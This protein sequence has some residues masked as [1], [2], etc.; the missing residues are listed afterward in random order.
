MPG[1]RIIALMLLIASMLGSCVADPQQVTWPQPPADRPVV[2][3]AF[4]MADDL[5]SATGTER[6]TF[7]PDAQICELVFR[8]WPNKPATART[9]NR[10][11]VESV[12]V[13]GIRL[14]LEVQAAGA[15]A[16]VPGTLVEATLP[17]CVPP[18][19][20]ITADLTF[21]LRLGDRTDERVG[22]SPQRRVAW[23]GS[24]YPMLAW[25]RGVGWTRDSAVDVV[26]ESATSEAFQLRSLT[27]EAPD[28][29][30]VAGMGEPGATRP[31]SRAGTNAHTFSSEVVRDVSVVVGRIDLHTS[32]VG[33]TRLTVALP[34]DAR[35]SAQVWRD[36]VARQLDELSRLLGPVPAKH[37]W[38]TVLPHV[39]EGVEFGEAVQIADIDP[40]SPRNRWLVAHEL[41]HL[42]FYGLVGNNQ[43]QHPWLDESF[44]TWAQQVVSPA[45]TTDDVGDGPVGGSMQH[46]AKA[47]DPDAAYVASVYALGGRTLLD[48]RDAVG[49]QT[50][51]AAI[52]GYLRGNAW[53]IATPADLSAALTPVPDAAGDL[54]EAGAFRD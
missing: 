32:A 22:L 43:A 42:W 19:R 33:D 38:I 27:V 44:A 41:A 12:A 1:A 10:L 5:A 39:S 46:W 53:R 7:T 17:A 16:G 20:A 50:F 21:S 37:V 31:G 18:G 47:P 8:A 34:A 13:G 54:R 35:A 49:A 45:D 6:V 29:D 11:T 9:G 36:Q 23:M 26:G 28:A 2:D 25:S 40:A 30:R 52:R 51:D 48:G 4:A 24:A 14:P 3:L 15:P